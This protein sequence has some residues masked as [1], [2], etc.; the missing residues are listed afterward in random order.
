MKY[1]RL[2]ILLLNVAVLTA[3]A[4]AGII[5]GK[6]KPK[7]DPAQRVPELLGIVK[8]SPDEGKRSDAAEELRK[9]DPVAFPEMIPTLL[10]VLQNDSKPSVRLSALTTLAKYRPV[11][12]EVGMALELA[13]AKD[14]SMRVRLQARSSLLGYH[15][16]GYRTPKNPPPTKEPPVAGPQPASKQPA[17]APLPPPVSTAPEPMPAAPVLESVPAP[18]TGPQRMP[19][20]PTRPTPVLR[21]SPIVVPAPAPK[22]APAGPDLGS[23]Y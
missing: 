6:K 16:G 20:G 7:V 2:L 15:W 22:R 21:T 9:Y 14:S 1:R 8:T 23:P 4:Q 10:D 19:M 13:Q 18:A 5:F 3:P 12:Q 17:P 11:S